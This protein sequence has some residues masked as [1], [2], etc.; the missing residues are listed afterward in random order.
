MQAR[1]HQFRRTHK[2][3]A[4]TTSLY[5]LQI[6]KY[7]DQD[8]KVLQAKSLPLLQ[9]ASG[10]AKSNHPYEYHNSPALDAPAKGTSTRRHAFQQLR[11]EASVIN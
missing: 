10:N 7:D 8:D 11:F 6:I 4:H 5:Y 1:D 9:L 3:S 2:D